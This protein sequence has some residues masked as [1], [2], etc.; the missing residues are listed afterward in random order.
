MNKIVLSLM[1]IMLL[2]GCS[3]IIEGS[4]QTVNISTG[5]DKQ[6]HAVITSSNGTMPVILP[7]ALAVNK[8]SNDLVINIKDGNCVLPS[9]TI[10]KSHLNPWFWG[11][12][13]F[14][15][16]IGSTTDSASGAAWEYDN[17][18]LVNVALKDGC[19]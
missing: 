15:G 10:V 16:V 18:I 2:S 17:N 9:T 6:I 19:Q 4:T 1:G 14:G 11:N 3:T 8:S 13:I 5:M 7:Q 12:I